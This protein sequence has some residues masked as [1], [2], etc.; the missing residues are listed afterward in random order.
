MSIR[1]KMLPFGVIAMPVA[2]PDLDEDA[3]EFKT[4]CGG[5]A[6]EC[7]PLRLDPKLRS[8]LL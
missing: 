8:A 7:F 4:R 2:R 6:R 5:E 3:V 1:N